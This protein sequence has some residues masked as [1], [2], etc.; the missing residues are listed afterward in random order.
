MRNKARFDLRVRVR[1][2]EED[3]RFAALG[4]RVHRV[5]TP[6]LRPLAPAAD[7]SG[8]RV[9]DTSIP[10]VCMVS[11]PK[12]RKTTTREAYQGTDQGLPRARLISRSDTLAAKAN[13]P[14]E[15]NMA[16]TDVSS[17]TSME[18]PEAGTID[19]KLEV[20]TLLV[21]D[22]DQAKRFY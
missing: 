8:V 15:V 21:S 17:K 18:M 3:L 1:R 4:R 22:V 13:R 6:R 20:V 2:E 14:A 5:S 11:G 19:M 10:I 12:R 16:S 7:S 9:A